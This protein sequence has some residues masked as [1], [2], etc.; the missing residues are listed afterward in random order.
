ME[1][2]KKYR[3][4]DWDEVVGNEAVVKSLRDKVEKG[5]LPHFIVFAGQPGCGKTTLSR[6]LKDKLGVQDMDF[7]E[8][9]AANQ[10]GVEVARDVADKCVYKPLGRGKFRMWLF[11]EAHKLTSACQQSMLKTLED[12]PEHAYFIFASSEADKLLPAIKSRATVYTLK[13]LEHNQMAGLLKRICHKEKIKVPAEVIEKIIELS[14]GQ[15]RNALVALDGVRDL[16]EEQ[17]LGAVEELAQ[18]QA[19]AYELL[20]ALLWGHG[21][22]KEIADVLKD[23]TEDPEQTRRYLMTVV[24]NRLKDSTKKD[25][26]KCYQLAYSMRKPFYDNGMN[27]LV[28]ACRDY[29]EET[30]GGQ[31]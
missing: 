21:T 26:D 27:D 28:F 25:H 3:P 16:D 24:C 18:Q 14:N 7:T 13:P 8:I 30:N 29:W 23:F 5:T 1:L 10:N 22:W 2:Y 19:K 9:N 17:M 6:I 4:S 12:T 15:S 31:K 11:D 20:K